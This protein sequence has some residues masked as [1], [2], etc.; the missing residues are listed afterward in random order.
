MRIVNLVFRERPG[1]QDMYVRPFGAD[2]QGD[3]IDQLCRETNEGTDITPGALSSTA[4]RIIRPVGNHRGQALISNGW[5]EKRFMFLMTAEVRNSQSIYTTLEIS[6]YTDS[7]DCSV[8]LRGVNLPNDLAMYFN[9]VTEVE[10]VYIGAPG[11]GAS[12][13]RAQV[14]NSCHVLIPQ[15]LPDFSRNHASVGTV[16]MR[17]TDIFR[18]DGDSVIARS[19]NQAATRESFIDVRHSFADRQLRMSNRW[20]DSPSR[21]LNRS[22]RALATAVE[23]EDF[24]NGMGVDTDGASA[25]RDARRQVPEKTFNSWRPL[26]DLSRDS[27]ILEQGFIT[28][29]E[30][31]DMNDDFP[32]DDIKIYLLDERDQ[33][34]F[35]ST[36]GWGGKDNTTIAATILARGL[37]SYMAF[38]QIA[39]LE[40]EANNLGFGGESMMMISQA[41]PFLGQTVNERALMAL[42]QRLLTELF[43]EMLPWEGCPFDIR[44]CASLSSDVRIEH[45]GIDTEDPGFFVF[46]VFCD[47]L[48]PPVIANSNDD[49]TAMGETVSKI[50]ES[51]GHTDNELRKEL[52]L[53]GDKGFGGNFNF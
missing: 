15:A 14:K 31:K 47:S 2:A 3:L 25:L 45:I 24:G 33:I 48:M 53:P 28:F 52:I 9:S 42:E 41:T 26:A 51:F 38:H 36:T 32:F 23:G 50:V 17:P 19:F 20:N 34:D 29:G 13:Y 40:F 11:M 39:V 22:L 35:R 49:V 43:M 1:Y 5:N 4:G 18:S 10:Q 37:P 21:Y 12:G 27:N 16:T 8:G 30:L 7:A 6:G 46:P 44:V